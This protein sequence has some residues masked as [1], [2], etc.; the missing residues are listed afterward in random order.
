MWGYIKAMVYAHNVN[1]REELFQR[2][3]SIASSINNA[4]VLRKFTTSLLKRARKCIQSDEEHLE[5]LS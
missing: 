2:I 1:T 3:L 4:A 5:Q